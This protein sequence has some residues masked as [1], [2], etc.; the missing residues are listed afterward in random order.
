LSARVAAAGR[1]RGAAAARARRAARRLPVRDWFARR[2]P[3]RADRGRAGAA[4][5]ASGVAMRPAAGT[6]AA[7]RRPRGLSPGVIWRFARPHTIVGTTISVA[8]LYVIALS[9]GLR[10]GAVSLA[11][12][13]LAAWLVNLTI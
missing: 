12:V 7:A 11:G 1:G 2:R 6:V 13:M 3:V 4:R 5:A 9:Q 8:A 10:P